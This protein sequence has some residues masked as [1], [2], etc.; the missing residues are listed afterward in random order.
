MASA[1]GPPAKKPVAILPKISIAKTTPKKAPVVKPKSNA[2]D[3]PSERLAATIKRTVS[4]EAA[5][6]QKTTASVPAT[7]ITSQAMFAAGD[8]QSRAPRGKMPMEKVLFLAHDV[9]ATQAIEQSINEK[10]TR[11]TM[12][13]GSA[14]IAD[15]LNP[16]TATVKGNSS[17]KGVPVVN[18]TATQAK[19]AGRPVSKQRAKQGTA[20]ET[21]PTML[22]TTEKKI[23]TG[24]MYGYGSA[25]SE[26]PVIRTVA[27]ST[28]V[29]TKE[30]GAVFL[31]VT[32]DDAIVHSDAHDHKSLEM[33]DIARLVSSAGPGVLSVLRPELTPKASAWESTEE[34]NAMDIDGPMDSAATI[35]HAVDTAQL[36]KLN[37]SRTKRKR[38]SS[39]SI[40]PTDAAQENLSASSEGGRVVIEDADA[41]DVDHEMESAAPAL[42]DM[43]AAA[44]SVYG[45]TQSVKR[46]KTAAATV[47]SDT[48]VSSKKRLTGPV[49]KG[50]IVHSDP[51]NLAG[52][53]GAEFQSSVMTNKK[54]LMTKP[55]D[56]TKELHGIV[57]TVKDAA[58]MVPETAF[59]KVAHL[60]GDL[61]FTSTSSEPLDPSESAAYSNAR[62]QLD[63]SEHQQQQQHYV[64]AADLKHVL[65]SFDKP[66]Q[67]KLFY[68]RL[69]A[70]Y[71]EQLEDDV[72][73]FW[74]RF[75]PA[76]VD[77]VMAEA[78]RTGDALLLSA[79]VDVE[80]FDYKHSADSS[81]QRRMQRQH[82]T[83]QQ[84]D[85]KGKQQP[86]S[87]QDRRHHEEI[88]GKLQRFNA[89]FRAISEQENLL[90]SKQQPCFSN[91]QERLADDLLALNELPSCPTLTN[92]YSDIYRRSYRPS[93]VAAKRMFLCDN[94]LDCY[95]RMV[96]IGQ[97][98]GSFFSN[99]VQS[100]F[101][102]MNSIARAFKGRSGIGITVSA[103]GASTIQPTGD[104]GK[105]RTRIIQNSANG[106]TP[107]LRG[108]LA[109]RLLRSVMRPNALARMS[110]ESR[111]NLAQILMRASLCDTELEAVL[112]GSSSDMDTV[113]NRAS[114]G[115]SAD[116]GIIGIQLLLPEEEDQLRKWI[117]SGANPSEHPLLDPQRDG[118]CY[119]CYCCEVNLRNN[120]TVQGVAYKRHRDQVN[121]NIHPKN[122]HFLPLNKFQ[123]EVDTLSGYPRDACISP[124]ARSPG[125]NMIVGHFPIFV[126]NNLWIKD[127]GDFYKIE[128]AG[129]NFCLSSDK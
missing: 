112:N 16:K 95:V 110:D 86:R 19:K 20:A 44:V 81:A 84:P 123:V 15:S 70:V 62:R 57:S 77:D 66:S 54:Q 59:E 118:L 23:Y 29:P 60:L 80:K 61:F 74:A 127:T 91:R 111:M 58:A 31:N 27:P 116:D 69:N 75:D 12:A 124:T 3:D 45:I 99:R 87:E 52:Q 76:I 129:A 72:L 105:L 34:S 122:G 73:Q 103:S 79:G 56:V 39:E 128:D 24:P 68:N 48:T 47:A 63:S 85:V 98:G 7:E 102:T 13:A 108:D 1:E 94:G 101:T 9:A 40:Y 65:A 21:D 97:S 49:P 82:D 28:S 30:T 32:S 107:L 42:L 6:Q 90:Q 37:T 10:V 22:G 88:A 14:V 17:Q 104:D 89:V 5:R 67:I 119:H 41:M 2:A 51:R 114:K 125:K 126:L 83:N 93:Q 117:D 18:A 96:G 71:K 33:G 38:A 55:T 43:S 109:E 35:N 121:V 4:L 106:A 46:Q 100:G 8:I 120:E 113:I 92:I 26:P 11:Q 53:D 25:I 50:A 64:A 78:E 115:W 36:T